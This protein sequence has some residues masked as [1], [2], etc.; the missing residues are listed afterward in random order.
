MT[1]DVFLSR[2]Y[3]AIIEPLLFV[4]FGL[5]AI[6]FIWGVVEFIQNSDN[7]K[8]REK[9]KQSMIWGVIGMVIMVSVFGIVNIVVG[10]IGAELPP[11][12]TVPRGEYQGTLDG[13]KIDD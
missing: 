8:D 10:T 7:D 3:A 6:I 4:I 2:V 13:I 1:I 5:A 12:T 11:N 9:G